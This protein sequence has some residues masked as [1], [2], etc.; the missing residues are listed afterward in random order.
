M[1]FFLVSVALAGLLVGCGSDSDDEKRSPSP[2]PTA[3][4]DQTATPAPTDNILGAEEVYDIWVKPSKS[5]CES[6]GGKYSEY[7]GLNAIDKK[8]YSCDANWENSNKICNAIDG[9]LPSIE[10]LMAAVTDCGGTIDG[11]YSNKGDNKD[12]SDCYRKSGL[13][14]EYYWSSTSLDRDSNMAWFIRFLNGSK[15]F[16]KKT[17]S[18]T[19]QCVRGN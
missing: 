11:H 5:V 6:N 8:E 15:D 18:L 4:Q 1:K 7:N 10:L 12:Y 13:T 3:I 2:D 14:P 16:N 17:Y 9:E 19:V